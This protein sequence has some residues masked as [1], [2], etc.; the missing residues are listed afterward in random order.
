MRPRGMAMPLEM[1]KIRLRMKTK[2]VVTIPSRRATS[3]CAETYLA[4]T[5]LILEVTRCQTRVAC[6]SCE[7]MVRQKF[8]TSCGP[9]SIKR[10]VRTIVRTILVKML[11]IVL[12]LLIAILLRLLSN[13][14]AKLRMAEGTWT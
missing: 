2:V 11:P 10:I 5:V 8:S 7:E 9:S 13:V 4:T 14:L 12:T 3:T 6:E 1:S